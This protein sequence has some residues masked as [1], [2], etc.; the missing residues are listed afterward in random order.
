MMKIATATATTEKI[1]VA[2]VASENAA[3]GLRI[4]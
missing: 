1:Q 4:R 2:P 3:P